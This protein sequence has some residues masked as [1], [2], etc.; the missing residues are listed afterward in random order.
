MDSLSGRKKVSRFEADILAEFNEAVVILEKLDADSPVRR[1]SNDLPDCHVARPARVAGV[2][3]ANSVG[4]W[5]CSRDEDRR[6]TLD[7]H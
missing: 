4:Q 7:A 3:L 6:V 2:R 5:N 1:L